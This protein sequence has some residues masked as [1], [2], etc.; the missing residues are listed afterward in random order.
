MQII[1]V[2]FWQTIETISPT[3]TTADLIFL[4]PFYVKDVRQ[5]R[6]GSEDIQRIPEAWFQDRFPTL[7]WA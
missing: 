3:S 5:E 4:T 1:A 2:I 6:V 7:F